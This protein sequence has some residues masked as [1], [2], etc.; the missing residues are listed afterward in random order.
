M[1]PDQPGYRRH[2]L[3]HLGRVAGRCA[4]LGIGAV[5]DHATPQHPERR[6]LTVGE[7]VNAMV[8]QGL[9]CLTQARYLVPRCFHHQPTERRIAPRLAPDQRTDEALGRAFETL[10]AYGVTALDRLLAAT[11]AA[12]LGLPPR[13]AP[14]ARTSVHV[15]GRYKRD[16]EPGEQVVPITRGS[17]RDHRPDLHHVMLARMVEPQAGIP[18]L[19]QPRRGNS[20]DAHDVGD[21]VAAHGQPW[22][23]T[24]G[25]T[26]LVAEHALSR[27]DTLR[28][29]AQTQRR[30]IT[31]VPATWS[32]AQAALAQ[33]A[34]HAR[35]SLTAGCRAGEWRSTDGGLEPRWRLLSSESR[36]PHAQ[37]LLD[38]QGGPPSATAVQALTT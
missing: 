2:V 11:A 5:L 37:R 21:G 1:R 24:D 31:R 29:L 7:A 33:V 28:T 3:A 9:G 6:D 30:W 34:P 10:S 16:A 35:A 18:R 17:R 13:L 19:L 14:R 15:D 25:T 27:A 38:R 26:D 12:P 36:Q 20:R 4:A 8:R 23:T 22:Q 32:E